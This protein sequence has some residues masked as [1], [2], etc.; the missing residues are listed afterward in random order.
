M[1]TV[2]VQ[3]R[4]SFASVLPPL[5]LR[6]YAGIEMCIIIIIII[7]TVFLVASLNAVGKVIVIQFL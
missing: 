5:K 2:L 4:Q 1:V 3:D 7:I 6:P